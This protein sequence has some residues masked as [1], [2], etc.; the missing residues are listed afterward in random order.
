MVF[1]HD[2]RPSGRASRSIGL[3]GRSLRSPLL[4]IAV[5]VLA[6]ASVFVLQNDRRGFQ[7]DHHGFLSSHGMAL[8]ANL[9]PEHHFLLFHRLSKGE[10]GAVEYDAYNRFPM[11]TFAIV[12]LLI[13]PFESQLGM[14]V[15]VA[16]MVMLLFFAAAV[17][18][19]FLALRRIT[20]SPWGSVA[21]VLLAFST[22]CCL[23]Y[24]DM[25]FCDVPALFGMMLICHGMLVYEQDERF[26]QLL[27]K[28]LIGGVLGWQAFAVLVPF[29]VLGV[30][31]DI[32]VRRSF[33]AVVRG[34]PFLLGVT[35]GMLVLLILV[36]NLIGESLAL[37]VPIQDLP[38][39]QRLIW[40]GGLGVSETLEHWLLF[41]DNQLL[42]RYQFHRRIHFESGCITHPVAGFGRDRFDARFAGRLEV[43]LG[44]GLGET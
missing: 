39:L 40:R 23:Y 11:G 9:S 30:V 36:G 14:Q 31:R 29:V 38:S 19:A 43:L 18:A 4:P 24:S 10:D 5:L 6:L 2:N 44:H 25:V 27:V 33:R 20:G 42:R 12:G 22:Y 35:A 37:G 3:A 17:V 7:A 26:R 16:R 8:A 34:A 1:P 21:V 15:S 41:L 28:V 13:L 32:F